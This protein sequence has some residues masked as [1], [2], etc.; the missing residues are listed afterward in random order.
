MAVE[1][2]QFESDYGFKSPGFT[3]DTEGNVVVKSLSYLDPDQNVGLTE[4]FVVTNAGTEFVFLD[5]VGT[6]IE[7]QN[8]TI[9]LLRGE[10]YIFKLELSQSLTFSIL[11]ESTN[12]TYDINVTHTTVDGDVTE[13]AD[14]QGKRTG[15]VSFV[16]PINSPDQLGYGDLNAGTTGLFSIGF[17]VIS[18]IGQFSE[19][20]V[21]GNSSLGETQIVSTQESLGLTSGA[22]VVSGGAAVAKDLNVGGDLIA[23]QIKTN[24]TGFATFETQTNLLFDVGNRIDVTVGN[25]LIGQITAEGSALKVVNTTIDNTVIGATTPAK[26]TFSEAAVSKI[27]TQ[28]TEIT[29]KTYVDLN[30]AAFAIALGT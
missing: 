10:T 6:P 8:P 28:P 15:F 2:T 7:G 22:L 5:S 13:G 12:N 20:I 24:G 14:A 16:V 29:N 4:D 17:P 19:L 23:D 3:V 18:G 27:A 25:T 26:A 11:N 1:L 9:N 21:S 30:S